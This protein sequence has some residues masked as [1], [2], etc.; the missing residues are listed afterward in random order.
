MKPKSLWCEKQKRDCVNA[1]NGMQ[2]CVNMT[3]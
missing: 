3:Y 2:H 1:V